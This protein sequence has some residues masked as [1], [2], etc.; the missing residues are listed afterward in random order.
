MPLPRLRKLN[1][2]G[3]DHMVVAVISVVVVGVVGTALVVASHA[4]TPASWKGS[5]QTFSNNSG[6]C[7]TANGTTKSSKVVLDPCSSSQGAKQIWSLYN[8]GTATVLGQPNTQEFYLQNGAGSNLCLNNPYRSKTNGTAMQLY[9]CNGLDAAGTWVWGSKL[10]S[11]GL[12]SHQLTSLA[13]ISGSAGK[14]LDAAYGS[15][16]AGTKVQIWSCKTSGQSNQNWFEDATPSGSTTGGGSTGGGTTYVDG[17]F[18]GSMPA[19]CMSGSTSGTGASGW[20]SLSFDDEFSGTSV[21]SSKWT[22][23]NQTPNNDQEYA[24]YSPSSV[25][26][27][28][29]DLSIAL[30][31]KSCSVGGKTYQYTGGQLD[32]KS[33]FMQTYGYYEARLYTPGSGGQIYNW[34]A[35]W[36]VGANWPDN[37]EIDTFEGF[38]GSAGW[39]FMY[40]SGGNPVWQGGQQSGQDFTGW[41]TYAVDWQSGSIKYYYDGKNVGTITQGVTS[42]PMD[43]RLDNTTAPQNNVGGPISVPQTMKVDYVRVWK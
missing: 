3:F 27:G 7:L 38:H 15:K 1:Q 25:S 23:E 11:K 21:S 24:C 19:P 41:H 5:L 6:Y 26:E 43:L 18:N 34:P 32:T 36:L 10:T 4:A 40:P 31:N 12:S 16:T 42:S 35:W 28:G 30:L 13:S 33:Q 14:C 39:H 17:C 20:G 2:S 37:G 9:T 8:V 22:I 29:G